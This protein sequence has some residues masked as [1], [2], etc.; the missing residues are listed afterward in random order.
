MAGGGD[1]PDAKLL[2]EG[3]I[4]DDGRYIEEHLLATTVGQDAALTK[5][6]TSP[7]RPLVF[8]NACQV[9]RLFHAPLGIGG[10]AES[11]INAGA[12]AFVSSLWSVGDEPA[13]TFGATF[14]TRLKAG[15][16]LAAATVAAREAARVANDAT[17]LAYV[18]YGH[19]DAVLA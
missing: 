3:R 6:G 2:L 10:F 16:T 14:Y 8:L 18:V 11:F 4:G 7:V 12:G 19:P 17:W 13:G 1:L 15:D 9:G 5:D